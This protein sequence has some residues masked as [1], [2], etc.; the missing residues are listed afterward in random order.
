MD[1]Y[2]LLND[3]PSLTCTPASLGR[4]YANPNSRFEIQF[5]ESDLQI[6]FELFDLRRN[7][8]FTNE[9]FD[10][11]EPS[12]RNLQSVHFREMGVSKASWKDDRLVIESEN[13]APG[14][15]R[16][17][18]GLPQSESTHSTEVFYLDGDS[19]MLD[20]TYE[21]PLL[22]EAPFT[23]IHRFR[24]SEAEELPI[25]ECTDASYDWFEQLNQTG[26]LLN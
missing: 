1:E 18:S 9:L 22:F 10:T 11:E 21:D 3:D 4:V 19:L 25:Y 2:D 17:S 26:E 6:N 8:P 23:I 16:T 20:L 12:T 7:I 5:S 14:Y 13:Y 15:I 24:R